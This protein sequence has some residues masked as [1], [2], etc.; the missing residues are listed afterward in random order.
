MGGAAE[1]PAS[2]PELQD[3]Q[4]QQPG[5]GGQPLLQ[6]E[7]VPQQEEELVHARGVH[8]LQLLADAMQLHHQAVYLRR[9]VGTSG[10]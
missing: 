4:E 10:V 3:L 8:L 1:R 9:R 2:G 6:Q 5:H 7:A